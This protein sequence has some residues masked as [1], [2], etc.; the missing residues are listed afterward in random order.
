[1]NLINGKLNNCCQQNM[2]PCLGSPQSL[3][4]ALHDGGDGGGGEGGGDQQHGHQGQ[5]RDGAALLCSLLL[6]QDQS[7]ASIVTSLHQSET[8]IVTSLHQSEASIETS[9]HQSQLTS[10]ASCS[11]LAVSPHSLLATR[12]RGRELGGCQN[13]LK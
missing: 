12:C 8:S 1:M 7:E 2:S 13:S 3:H 10:G 9:L 11:R 4:Q 6:Q 5:S